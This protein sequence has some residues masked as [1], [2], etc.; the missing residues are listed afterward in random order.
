EKSCCRNLFHE[1]NQREE[2]VKARSATQLALDLDLPPMFLHDP[3]NDGEAK[4]CSVIFGGEKRIED[5][6]HI[7]WLNPGSVIFNRNAQD[8]PDIARIGHQSSRPSLSCANFGGD[9]KRPARLHGIESVD[10]KI[11]KDLFN[12]ISVR[13]DSIHVRLPGTS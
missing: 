7:F 13:A 1:A 12:L 9:L 11:E 8:L 3:V 4:S 10:E 6:R 5:V 2:D